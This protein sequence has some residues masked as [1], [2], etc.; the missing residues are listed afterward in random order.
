LANKQ[1]Y[2]LLGAFYKGFPVQ[3]KADM[4]KTDVYDA[5]PWKEQKC[6]KLIVSISGSSM[7]HPLCLLHCFTLLING[8]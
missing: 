4:S 1:L 8:K 7:H 3:K 6:N 5:T 2:A